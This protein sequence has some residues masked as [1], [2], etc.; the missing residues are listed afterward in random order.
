[1]KKIDALEALAVEAGKAILEIYGQDDFQIVSKDDAS[2]LTAA[3]LASHEIIA[4]GLAAL[5]P[6]IPVLS[7]E[8]VIGWETRREWTRYWLVDPLDGTKEFIKR[9]GEFTVNIA[10]IE[11]GVPTIGVVDLPLHGVTY[12]GVA[13]EGAY[14]REAGGEKVSISPRPMPAEGMVVSVSRSHPSESVQRLMARFGGCVTRSLGSALKFCYVADG[15]VDFY[16]RL[17]LT[18]EWDTAAAQA[19]LEAAGGCIVRTDGSPLRYNT[20]ESLLNPFFYAIGDPS[21]LPAVL[22]A[23]EQAGLEF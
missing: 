15:Q 22:E 8:S 18:S 19:V 1:M 10:L 23:A 21:F 13:G 2:P 3:D 14:K 6:E 11:D 16:P 7:E 4:A 5:T 17:G 20:K 12:V 9:N